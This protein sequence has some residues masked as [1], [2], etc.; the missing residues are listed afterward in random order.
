MFYSEKNVVKLFS[1]AKKPSFYPTSSSKTVKADSV[2][3]NNAMQ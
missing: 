2:R 1:V 3:Y